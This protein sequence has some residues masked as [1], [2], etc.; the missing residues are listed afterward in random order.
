MSL[1]SF[2]DI[3]NAFETS[4]KFHYSYLYKPA[5]PNSL[6]TGNFTDIGQSSG[7]PKYQPYSGAALSALPLVGSGND[8]INVGPFTT[9]D[10]K[11]LARMQMTTSLAPCFS[12]LSDYLLVYPLI[13]C[14]ETS[15]Q[16]MDNTLT[17]PRYQSGEGVR[18]IMVATA[19]M[20]VGD[21]VT[22]KYTNSQGVTGRTSTFNLFPAQGVG[23]CPT[24]SGTSSASNNVVTPFWPLASGDT[25]MRAI[26]SVTFAASCG[27]FLSLVLVKPL[28]SISILENFYPCE[29]VFLFDQQKAP[30]ILDGAYLNFLMKRGGVGGAASLYAELLFI[31]T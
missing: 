2:G 21:V 17:L 20:T 16:V 12:E 14:D 22:V 3:S 10:K 8:G 5:I 6:A 30:E 27:G 19:P 13:D 18:L 1:S 24:A 4:G 15:E 7:I 28:A 31:N 9:G 23:V 25:G 26:E 29:K 11:Y